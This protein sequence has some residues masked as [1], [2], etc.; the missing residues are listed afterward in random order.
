MAL[1][2]IE[3]DV[4]IITVILVVLSKA[5]RSTGIFSPRSFPHLVF[6][7]FLAR[8][9]RF[10]S[11]MLFRDI[12]DRFNFVACHFSVFQVSTT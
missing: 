12:F 4:W 2:L 10:L 6:H 5:P 1:F 9:A 3:G 8:N 11:L 7:L